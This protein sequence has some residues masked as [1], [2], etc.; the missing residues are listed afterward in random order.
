MATS[1]FTVYGGSGSGVYTSYTT[2]NISAEVPAGNTFTSWG[3]EYL[4][5][6]SGIDLPSAHAYIWG[7]NPRCSAHWTVNYYNLGYVAGTGG[8]IS[9]SSSQSVAYGSSGSSVTAVPNTGYHFHYWDDSNTNATRSD[10]VYGNNTYTAIFEVDPPTVGYFNFGAASYASFSSLSTIS[11]SAWLYSTTLGASNIAKIINNYLYTNT[12]GW[13]VGINNATYTKAL[14]FYAGWSGG[15]AIW[16]AENSFDVNAWYHVCVTYDRSATA[17]N[18]ILYSNGVSK[19]VTE[20]AAPSGTIVA[21]ST[22]TLLLG[23]M[24]TG[25][26]TYDYFDGLIRDIRIY[27]RIL[28]PVEVVEIYSSRNM[29]N[30]VAGTVFAPIMYGAKGLQTFDGASLTSANTILDPFSKAV[31][32]P[33][34]TELGVGE[35][36]LHNGQ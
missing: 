19:S 3:D 20:L 8:T 14:V 13:A 23:R 32:T 11:I 33:D 17:N 2:V 31:G 34:G 5:N 21:D 6:V 27:N 24:Q 29:T 35:R 25:S 9:G 28:S 30:N 22:N 1:S 16:Y 12:S 4:C 36:L 18:P 7:P 26:G 15:A 10:M